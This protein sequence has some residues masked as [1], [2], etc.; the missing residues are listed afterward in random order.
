MLRTLG[1]VL[2]T[3]A[4]RSRVTAVTG[5]HCPVSGVWAPVGEEGA[6]CRVLEGSLMPAFRNS[7]AEWKLLEG[8]RRRDVHS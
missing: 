1:Q 8:L 6:F 5:S 7:A 3:G 2:D 4:G